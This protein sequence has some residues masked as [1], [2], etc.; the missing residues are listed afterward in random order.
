MSRALPFL[1]PLLLVLLP[2]LPS[3]SNVDSDYD[4]GSFVDTVP[5]TDGNLAI[6]S[7]PD[8]DDDLD[9]IPN[10]SEGCLNGRDSDKDKVPDWLD[11]DSDDDKI[12]DSLEAGT[13]GSDG[14]CSATKKT[15]PCDTDGD[16]YPDYLDEDSDGDG[17]KDGAEDINGDGLVGC[18]LA[19][20]NTP[21]SSAQK[22]C[23]LGSTGCGSGQKC[24]S[25]KCT[26]AVAFSC[27][28]GETNP[29][30]KDT[31]GDGK[32]DNERGTFICRDAT[33]DNPKGRKAV[34]TRSSKVGDWNVAY[35]PAASIGDI[36]ISGGGSKDAA[37]VIDDTTS[38][39]GTAGF[40]VS[41][42]ST[43]SS[44]QD[45]LTDIMSALNSKWG[46]NQISSTAS[47]TEG[48]THDLYD[49]VQ[50]TILDFNLTSST[51]AVDLRNTL[52]ATL[53]GKN[54]S[55]LSNLP[56]SSGTST[57]AF[58]V[59][60]LTIKRVEFKKDSKG[61]ILD[62]DGNMI[63]K[64]GKNP[65]DSGDTAKWRL[66]VMGA[67]AAKSDYNDSTKKTGI[68]VEDLSNG[69]AVAIASDTVE[70]SCDVGTLTSMPIADIV[71]VIDESGS[72]DDDRTNIVNNANNFFSR[73]LS[74]GLDFRMGVTG[75]TDP[76][77]TSTCGA[78]IIGK[79][80]SQ[81]STNS[82]DC[83]GTDRFIESSEQSVFSS[84]IDNPPGYE[85]GSEYGLINAK[86]ATT[87]HLPR[88]DTDT[89]KFRTTSKITIIV[90]SDEVPNEIY[91]VV[92]NYSSCTLSSSDQTK[93]DAYLQSYVD[94]WTGV[95]D[96]EA[97]ATF[98][99]LGGVCNNSCSADVGHGYKDLA[100]KLGGQV[101]DLCQKDLGST[102]QVIIDSIVGDA[103]PIVLEYVPISSSL[104]VTLDATVLTR[105]RSNGFDYRY[106]KNSLAFINVKFKK[107]SQVIASYKRWKRQAE[108][109]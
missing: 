73:A 19:K 105:S 8:G 33:E 76:S 45:E 46:G 15:W 10:G 99:F 13:K 38:T 95:T 1:L 50:G 17:L 11:T 14:K 78:A 25:G 36:T 7:D 58:V 23:V 90:A 103:S 31:F 35:D 79:F 52:I 74:S 71:W 84:C 3:C 20:C 60:F 26:P 51:T 107:G 65:A 6:C 24:V 69:T 62:E 83:G 34:S 72:M 61:N 75:V 86:A 67:V 77:Y 63:S 102:L 54:I 16:Q 87:K 104:A 106:N 40:I 108:I 49:T 2:S 44:V 32:L 12:P 93:L 57:T 70:N 55:D 5:A 94:L 53:L 109:R 21:G 4:G 42:D 29:Y 22:T 66:V 100:Q 96:A 80:C 101:G 92:G 56:S 64:S 47:G 48:H 81:V 85:G 41:T 91:G 37:A 30:K 88:D 98:H 27:S 68:S 97:V 9:G 18:C 59:R 28:N 82:S 39:V 89:S 43:K